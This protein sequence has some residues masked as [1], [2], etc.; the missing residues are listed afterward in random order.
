VR[1]ER[2]AELSGKEKEGNL[3]SLSVMSVSGSSAK[4]EGGFHAFQFLTGNRIWLA[5]LMEISAELVD[6]PKEL[7]S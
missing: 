3:L 6:F 4:V 7:H 2:A 1:R 5:D